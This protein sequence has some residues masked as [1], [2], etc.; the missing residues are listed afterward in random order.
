MVDSY[1]DIDEQACVLSSA[2]TFSSYSFLS[3]V[4]YLAFVHWSANLGKVNKIQ[5]ERFY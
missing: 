5:A 3:A 1:T 4:L 2:T